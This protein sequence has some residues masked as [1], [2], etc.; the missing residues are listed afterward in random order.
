[1]N[2]SLR[3]KNNRSLIEV[4]PRAARTVPFVSK[5]TGVPLAKVAARVMAGQTPQQGVT[6]DYP[7]VLLVKNGAA[8][9]QVPGR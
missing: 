6:K 3:K 1:M 4:N 5:A 8:V 2:D 7:A 9:Q